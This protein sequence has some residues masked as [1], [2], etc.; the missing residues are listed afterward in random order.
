M[1]IFIGIMIPFIGTMLGSLMV[2]FV[3]NNINKKIESILLGIA[4]GVMIAASIWS[5]I[6]PSL[7]MASKKFINPWLPSSIGFL[8][9]ILVLVVIDLV[10]SYFNSIRK[11]A[12]G[13]T[14]KLRNATMLVFVVTLH[15][16]PEGMAVGVAFASLLMNCNEISLTS[17]FILA[18]GIAIQNFPE[19]AIISLP[20]KSN[21]M[22]KKKALFYGFL[23]AIVEPIAAAITLLL[24][25]YII[26][27]LPCLLSFAAG[28]MI[29]VVVY[30]LIPELKS[31]NYF[32][33]SKIGI[34]FGF[35]I[36]ML[37]DIIFG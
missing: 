27:L 8:L 21:G 9:G 5:L 28:A 24:T 35:V 23:S 37:L 6:I 13:V 7:E 30:E 33:V 25:N 10:V 1:N 19:G 32:N 14:N 22:S 15:N 18:I 29:Y 17:S 12:K 2:M 3:K 34:A 26:T 20:L 11:N 36:M 4:S 16:I 31:G